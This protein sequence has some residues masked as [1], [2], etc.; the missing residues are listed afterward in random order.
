M[1][2]EFCSTP[3]PDLEIHRINDAVLYTLRE[4]GFGARSATD[5]VFAEANRGEVAR[6]AKP[7]VHRK[8]FVFAEISVPSKVLQF[9]AFIHKDLFR[10]Q[11][12][13]L[14]IYDTSFEGVAD[15]NDPT[16]VLD[17]LEMME[18]VESLGVGVS[19]C[20]SA[21]IGLYGDLL[22]SVCT[23]LAWDGTSFRGYRC[24]IDYPI[25]GSQICLA[26]DQPHRP[27]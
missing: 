24:R 23:K 16:R 14:R 15:P 8:T 7:G 11:D 20:R 1:L 13:S 18:T 27:E 17:R 4:N 12:P 3:A 6:Y 5:V 19:R 10:G 25:Y 26:W 9:D 2:R 22:N 21:D